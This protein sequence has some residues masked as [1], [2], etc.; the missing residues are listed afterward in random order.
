MIQ[1]LVA[2]WRSLS[3]ISALRLPNSFMA[4][5]LSDGSNIDISIFFIVDV[6]A[7]RPSEGSPSAS[8]SSHGKLD[9]LLS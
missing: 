4:N 7:A 3:F 2:R 9:L 8:A 1:F 6:Q 5:L